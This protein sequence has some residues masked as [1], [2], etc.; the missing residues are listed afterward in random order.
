MRK[1]YLIFI[2]LVAF[3]IV[4][5]INY[6]NI[7]YKAKSPEMAV[8]DAFKSTN[9]ELGSSEVYIKTNLNKKSLNSENFENI[10]TEIGRSVTNNNIELSNYEKNGDT[11]FELKQSS[12]YSG[13]LDLIGYISKKQDCGITLSLKQKALGDDLMRIRT[14]AESSFKKLNLVPEVTINLTAKTGYIN[15]TDN[16]KEKMLKAVK[17]SIVNKLEDRNLNWVEVYSPYLRESM[18]LFEIKKSN[19]AFSIR[20]NSVEK[21]TY[22]DI[23]T[24]MIKVEY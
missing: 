11:Y 24:P 22:I 20:K 1:K 17:G 3:F 15:N 6:I 13:D 2:G 19:L 9:A 21:A 4:F 16:L 18:N 12:K 5:T 14:E 8:T 23:G 7:Q 10:L